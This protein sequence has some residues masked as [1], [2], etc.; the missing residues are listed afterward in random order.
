MFARSIATVALL[1]MATGALGAPPPHIVYL[2]ADDL[3]WK[4]VGYH[5]GGAKTP[6]LD[7]LAAAGARLEKFYTLPYST[8]T[9]AALMTGRYPMRYG[10]QTQSILPWSQFGLPESEKTIAQTLREAGY[11]TAFLGKWQLGH[12]SRE[13]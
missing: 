6:N 5:G 12:A 1:C 8:P 3:G 9:R 10:L 11:R 13:R 7:R 4:D 2:L